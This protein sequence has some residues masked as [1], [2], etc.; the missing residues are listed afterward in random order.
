MIK[1]EKGKKTVNWGKYPLAS[2]KPGDSFVIPVEDINS[3]PQRLA[4]QVPLL[5]KAKFHGVKL[6]TRAVKAGENG[7]KQDGIRVWLMGEVE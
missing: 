5:N 3:R 2:M 1:V 6:I 4:K 7:E